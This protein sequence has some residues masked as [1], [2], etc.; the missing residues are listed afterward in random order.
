MAKATAEAGADGDRCRRR[1]RHGGDQPGHRCV[2]IEDDG[3]DAV[4]ANA[5]AGRSCWTRRAGWHGRTATALRSCDCGELLGNFAAANFGTDGP[6]AR[7][8]S[9]F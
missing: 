4:V 6:A 9:W 1:R 8:I 5:V 7:R 3:P 2:P